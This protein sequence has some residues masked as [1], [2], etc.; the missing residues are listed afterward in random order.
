MSCQIY[1][2]YRRHQAQMVLWVSYT[3]AWGRLLSLIPYKFP[4]KRPMLP[5]TVECVP[6]PKDV[7]SFNEWINDK[8][9]ANYETKHNVLELNYFGRE[10]QLGK[11]RG[12]P[13]P[14]HFGDKF[15]FDWKRGVKEPATFSGWDNHTQDSHKTLAPVHTGEWY[16]EEEGMLP[17]LSINE[18]QRYK[19]SSSCTRLSTAPGTWGLS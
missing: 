4:P 16:P 3:S 8:T 9:E 11:M 15:K 12:L 7:C 17:W 19:D 1:P 14:L 5:E 18:S 6:N 10:K 2:L 13:V